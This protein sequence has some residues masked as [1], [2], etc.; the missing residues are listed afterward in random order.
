MKHAKMPPQSTTILLYPC[1]LTE[2][3]S[4]C[5]NY[6][7]VKTDKIISA[8]KHVRPSMKKATATSSKIPLVKHHTRLSI[9][10]GA[11]SSSNWLASPIKVAMEHSQTLTASAPSAAIDIFFLSSWI[12]VLRHL[13][14]WP[15]P[16]RL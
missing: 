12:H 5:P 6:K 2:Y 3:I 15:P 10:H 4:I 14:Y 1:F 7:E 8:I 11:G 9:K 16:L 13:T